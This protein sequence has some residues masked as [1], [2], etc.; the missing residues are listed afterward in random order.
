MIAIL[1]MLIRAYFAHLPTTA[2]IG[3]K[4]GTDRKNNMINVVGTK[5]SAQDTFVYMNLTSNEGTSVQAN[6]LGTDSLHLYQT[7]RSQNGLSKQV[8][9][10]S[11]SRIIIF[12]DQS[13]ICISVDE[14][15]QCPSLHRRAK[16]CTPHPDKWNM[17]SKLARRRMPLPT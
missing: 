8:S 16:R 14:Y 3:R 9:H 5:S 11:Y 7:W 17:E 4:E 6:R 1:R 13:N 10:T 12:K 15:A 2:T